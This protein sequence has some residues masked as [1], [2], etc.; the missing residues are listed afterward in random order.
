[1]VFGSA[2]DVFQGRA[3]SGLLKIVCRTVVFPTFRT[4]SKVFVLASYR[5]RP[6]SVFRTINPVLL[7]VLLGQLGEVHTGR[8]DGPIDTGMGVCEWRQ[9][10]EYHLGAISFQHH[11]LARLWVLREAEL[12]IL[13]ETQLLNPLQS[14]LDVRGVLVEV[15]GLLPL[16]AV[17]IDKMDRV[18]VEAPVGVDTV[19]EPKR[20]RGRPPSEPRRVVARAVILKPALL[21][22][23]LARVAIALQAHLR[24]AAP[25]LIRRAAVGVVL[26][27]GDDLPCVVQLQ[28]W[29]SRGGCRTGSG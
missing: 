25:G 1:M 17:R 27:V 18:V 11:Q 9:L 14:S 2:T 6:A 10:T 15:V 16:T 28:D 4:K 7:H 23:L 5:S 21:I 26:L 12:D 29:P 19:R 13:L 22:A 24:R 20:I 3:G 8:M